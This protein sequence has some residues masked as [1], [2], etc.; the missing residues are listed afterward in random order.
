MMIFDCWLKILTQVVHLSFSINNHQST[1]NNLFLALGAVV[2]AA[3]GDHDA[4]NQRFADQTR[5]AFAAVDAM[6]ELEES[7]FALGV[8]VVGNGGAAKR[9][10]FGEHFFYCRQQLCELI[11]A[12][13]CRPPSRPDAG[14]KERFIS[15]NVP[16]AAQELLVEKCTLDRS[17]AALE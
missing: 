5:F 2:A 7:F 13:R 11:A 3:A 1:S 12:N 16:Y 9:D 8:D 10:G 15:V 6:L 14:A 4:L 17:L